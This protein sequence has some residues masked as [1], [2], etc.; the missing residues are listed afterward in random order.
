MMMF[1]RKKRHLE[2]LLIAEDEPL[3]AFDNERF[4]TD[5]GFEVVATV[6]RVA[7]AVALIDEGRAIDLILADISL[8][9]GSGVDIARAA[10]ARGIKVLFVT[11]DGH[12]AARDIA[13]GCLDKPYAQRDLLLAIAAIEAV[14][15][16]KKP[17]RLPA[18]MRLFI[19]PAA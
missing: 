2:R 16:G 3:V 12:E 18:G 17:R 6:D 4:L 1:G 9:D 8:A 19:A 5:A 15:G 7:D 14:I 10:S 11:G 13:A